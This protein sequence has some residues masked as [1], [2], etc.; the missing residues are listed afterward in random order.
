VKINHLVKSMKKLFFLLLFL[1]SSI[2]FAQK[3][4]ITGKV[5]DK[6]Q[7]NEPLPFCN[8]IVKGTTNGT[9]T[10]E[11][12][13]YTISVDPGKITIEFS[14]IG[15]K[16]IL[17]PI[18]V[19]AGQTLKLNQTLGAEEGVALEDV[20]ITTTRR[21]NTVSALVLEIKQ[22][23][24]VVNA[25]SAEQITKGTD[26]NVAE[27]IQRV[28]GVTIVDGRYLMIRGLSQRYNNVLIN[29]AIAPSTEI[30]MKTFSFDLIPTSSVEKILVFKTSSPDKPA[31]MTGGVIG[32]TTSEN[33]TEYT[34]FGFSLGYIPQTTFKDFSI[35]NGSSTDFLGFDNGYRQL[36]GNFPSRNVFQGNNF[37]PQQIEDAAHTLK[38]NFVPSN[39]SAM[40]QS[41][42]K[43]GIGRKF[44]IGNVSV[45]SDNTVQQSTSYISYDRIFRRYFSL[46]EG[47]ERPQDWLSYNDATFTKQN[48]LTF[49]SNWIFD[50]SDK[51]KLKFKNL[52]NQIGKDETIL[53]N[54]FNYQQKPDDVFNN[55]SLLYNQRFILTSQLE[56]EYKI[57]PNNRLDWVV[58]FNNVTDKTPDWRR[59]RT[60]RPIDSPNDPFIMI[61]PPSSN[62]FDTS[63]F[64]GNSNEYNIGNGVDYTYTLER[65]KGEEEFAPYKFKT[66]YY[67]DFRNKTFDA[68]YFSYRLPGNVSFD[69]RE[70]LVRQPLSTIFSNA[71]V[72]ATDGWA[73]QEGTGARDKFSGTNFYAAGYVMAELPVGKFDINTGVRYEYNFQQLNATDD[74]GDL[75][76]DYITG[77]L[78]PSLNIA[79]VFNEKNQL[80]F[81]YGRTLNR[82]EFR[83]IAPFLF[84]DFVNDR[85]ITGAPLEVATIDNFDLRYEFYPRKG[86]T[87]SLGVFNK[88]FKNPIE[89][90]AQITT[91]Q[92]QFRMKNA[93]KAFSRGVELEFRKSFNEVF[94]SSFLQK[95]STNINL[96]YILSEVDLGDVTSQQQVRALQGQ[97]PYIINVA[98]DYQDADS[99]INSSLIFNRF[100]DRI[101][102]VGDVIFPSIYELS[103]NNLDFAFS[104]DF[105]KF[106]VKFSIK[107]L[108]NSP[109]RFY[110]DSDRNEKIEFSRDNV[111]SQF[112]RGSLFELALTYKL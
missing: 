79:Y 90:V 37:S 42:V 16:S 35:S 66:G 87:I 23:K 59:F 105:K 5:L 89:F 27:A 72:N 103:R 6:E 65:I 8:V 86:E 84:Y 97:S 52:I 14:F 7:N 57:N 40:L 83:E 96:A 82:P 20:V 32:V 12:G 44:N 63:R 58:G 31:D 41:S 95:F 62:L 24:S 112:K 19:K 18:V 34:S 47:Q 53:R 46:N 10:D 88:S 21:K 39:E 56:G 69:R 94:K 100:G 110:E 1:S 2:I 71:N 15:Y 76:K 109:F 81:G 75:S 98:L 107:D 102:T 101:D 70:F 33:T 67:V 61:D 68:R 11:N 78:L 74:T 28:P 50:F 106:K 38:N 4:I 60:F 26:S 43:F 29:G 80:R 22:A 92:P 111:V 73:L 77:F 9:T 55:Y 99:G 64:F 54:G 93:D 51:F 49:V 3:A 36:P 104:K 25:I 13:H 30:D 85:G 91:E 108:L 17:V 48:K 45:F